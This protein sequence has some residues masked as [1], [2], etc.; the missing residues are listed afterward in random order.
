MELITLVPDSPAT[1]SLSPNEC[2]NTYELNNENPYMM[3]YGLEYLLTY[4]THIQ[5][6]LSVHS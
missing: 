2:S 1:S 3:T 6:I 5:T 4:N